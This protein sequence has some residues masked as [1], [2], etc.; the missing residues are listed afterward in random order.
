MQRIPFICVII[1]TSV[2]RS[3]LSR[4]AL[5]VTLSGQDKLTDYFEWSCRTIGASSDSFDLLIFHEGNS[6]LKSCQ[7][8]EN[9]KF[10]DLST[11]G[12]SKLIV[13]QVIANNLRAQLSTSD[14][15]AGSSSDHNTAGAATDG[16]SGSADS[17]TNESGGRGS[18]STLREENRINLQEYL[19]GVLKRIPRYL[20]EV[21]PMYGALF[22]DYLSGYSHWA[23]T[24]PDI[25]YGN[26]TNWIEQKDLDR[27]DV[28]SLG[29][30]FDAAR[31][32]LR[33]Q[34]T[35]LKNT[36]KV[37]FLWRNL[38]YFQP[39]S[40]ADRIVAAFGMLTQ[41]EPAEEIFH[42]KFHSPEGWWSDVVFKS[43]LSVK[44][45]GR[46]LDEYSLDPVVVS[47]GR[48]ARCPLQNV[49][50]CLSTLPSLFNDI[51]VY[52]LDAVAVKDVVSYHDDSA[53][54]MQ[55]LPEPVRWCIAVPAYDK[56]MSERSGDRGGDSA[57][58]DRK[59]K[60]M[61]T[62]HRPG[63]DTGSEGADGSS[64]ADAENVSGRRKLKLEKLGEVFL[65]NG[66]WYANDEMIAHR[67]SFTSGAF[68]HLGLWNVLG[69]SSGTSKT[70]WSVHGGDHLL[71]HHAPERLS[72][73]DNSHAH[74]REGGLSAVERVDMMGLHCMFL[75]VSR[76]EVVSF[77]ACDIVRDRL[78]GEM[79]AYEKRIEGRGGLRRTRGAAAAGESAD[80]KSASSASANS[81]GASAGAG[82]DHSGD[83]PL[84]LPLFPLSVIPSEEVEMKLIQYRRAHDAGKVVL[85]GSGGGGRRGRGS[86]G[87]GRE[88]RGQRRERKSE[89]RKNRREKRGRGRGRGKTEGEM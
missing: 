59:K 28:I 49:T 22:Q 75:Y 76:L 34:F 16:S 45:I 61:K 72:K 85:G 31:L 8:A 65:E 66:T 33:E 81:A 67:Q 41:H 32:F 79:R 37:N 87:N 71:S 40:F 51:T 53:C 12:L 63:A 35:L 89:R 73:L 21:K 47:H 44:I 20:S 7:C 68:F 74:L 39:N 64:D 38:E 80:G 29:R 48:I 86:G 70:T 9:V 77:E 18:G 42:S 54:L 13:S 56:S 19:S 57:M 1:V 14:T 11:N 83:L 62:R 24:D 36:E 84:P 26:L 27:F 69:A 25:I 6:R 2:F 15:S 5:I 82:G 43:G 23:Y 60:R 55:W 3:T 10:I 52:D 4:T 88:H 17:M 58:I 30:T 78:Q 46:A 50:G